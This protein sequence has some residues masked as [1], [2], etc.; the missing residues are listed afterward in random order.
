M[1]LMLFV[2]LLLMLVLFININ[3]NN[4]KAYDNITKKHIA[5]FTSKITIMLLIF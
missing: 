2:V 5:W 4:K 1:L 3:L